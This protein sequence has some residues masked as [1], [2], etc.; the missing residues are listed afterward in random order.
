MSNRMRSL[1]INVLRKE[2]EKSKGSSEL[3]PKKRPRLR[4]LFLSET[5]LCACFDSEIEILIDVM[6]RFYHCISLLPFF[7]AHLNFFP[8][9]YFQLGL[10]ITDIYILQTLSFSHN[11]LK[12]QKESSVK[13]G[14]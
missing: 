9:F 13:S 10:E 8:H 7:S 1:K 12:S 14:E 6:L 2:L 5:F 3:K 4:F 11:K